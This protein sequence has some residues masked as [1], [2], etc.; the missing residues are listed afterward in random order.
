[1][2]FDGLV[3]LMEPRIPVGIGIFDLVGGGNVGREREEKTRRLGD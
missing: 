3:D 1:M 2:A